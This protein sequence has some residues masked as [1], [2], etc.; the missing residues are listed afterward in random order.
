MKKNGLFK[1][2]LILILAVSAITW[3][4]PA[5]YFSGSEIADLGMNRIGF[6]DFFNFI[7]STFIFKYFLQVVFFILSIGALY[8]VLVKTNS[9]REILEKIVKSLK[10]KENIFLIIAAFLFAG[11]SSAFGFQIIMFIFIP[12]IISIILFYD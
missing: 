6:F 11:L 1:I 8:G 3:I 10:G 5:S 4:V 2:I 9:Y 7:S 12:A